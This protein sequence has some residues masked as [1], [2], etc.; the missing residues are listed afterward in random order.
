MTSEKHIVLIDDET[1]VVEAVSEML[2]LEGFRV[3]SFTD[4]NL[5]LKSLNANS[6]SV[7]LCDVRMPQVDG[8]TLLSSIQHRAANV[9][10]LLMSGHGDIPM[11]IEAM[12]LG[13]FDFLEKPLNA[14]ELVEK[15]DLAL[16]QC[17]QN[18][19]ATLDDD[20]DTELPIESVVIGQSQAMDTIRKQ[21]LALSHTGV[22]TIINGETGTGKEVIARALH[23]FSRRKTKPFVAINCGGMTESIIES[24]LFGHEAGSFTSAN[25]KRIGKIEQANGGTLFL[26]EIESMPI[27]VQIKLLRVIQERVIERV[28]GN[29][30]IPVDIV[31]VAASKADLASLS[32]SGEFRADLFYRLNIASLSL[33]ALRQR[34]EDIQVLFRHFVIQASHKYKT[35]PSTIYPEQIQQLCRHEWPGNVRELRNVADR[36]VL[37]IVGDGFDLQSPICESTGED[38]AFEKQMDQYERNVLTEALI[39]SAGNINEVSSK[40]NLPRKTLYRK[41]KKHQLDKES[42][43]A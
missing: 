8:L 16:A 1:D 25:K 9:P 5:G 23:Q 15:L 43:K 32:E 20:Q 42:F 19:P 2:E 41:M 27:A 39:E 33:P 24:E 6:Q 17:Q 3:T 18:S 40:L 10:V 13:A 7:V 14:S 31:V 34:K 22:D 36:F 30:L 29:E 38:F 4:P 12:K 26:D 11:A 21:V 35:R 37:G 28:G